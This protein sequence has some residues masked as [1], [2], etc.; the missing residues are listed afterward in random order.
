MK[1]IRES[2]DKNKDYQ[3]NGKESQWNNKNVQFTKDFKI[4]IAAMTSPND[5]QELTDQFIQSKE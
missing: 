5:F 2:R 1:N 3:N 4:G